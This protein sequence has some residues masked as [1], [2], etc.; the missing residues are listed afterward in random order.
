MSGINA[1]SKQNWPIWIIAGLTLVNGI[2]NI[3]YVLII[4][5]PE[6]SRV[7][8]LVLPYGL[9][10]WNRS[11]TLVFGFILMYLSLNLLKR[12][13]TA[14]YLTMAISVLIVFLHI[15][16]KNVI[17]TLFPPLLLLLLLLLWHKQFR[18][19]SEP[20]SITRGLELMLISLIIAV[21]YGTLGFW[22]LDK[23]DFGIE[24][25]LANSLVR[26]L[27]EFVLV[28]NNGLTANTRHARWFIDSIRLL[29]TV[30]GFFAMYSLF[31]PIVYR[32]RM[33]PHERQTL[34]DILDE[35]GRC[36]L[37]YFK[38]W[39]DKS[40]FFS[41]NRKCG[42]AYKTAFG[43]AI[44]LGDPVGPYQEIEHT[45]NDF[46]NYCSNNGWSIAFYQV[47]PDFLNMY[48][49]LGFGIV[50]IGEEA[51]INLEHFVSFTATNKKFRSIRRKFEKQNYRCTYHKPPHSQEIPRAIKQVSREWLQLAGRKERTFSV[52]EFRRDYVNRTPFFVISDPSGKILAFV[53]E[54]PSYHQGETTIDLMRHRVNVP[55]GTMDYLLLCLLVDLKERGYTRF[56]LGLAPLSGIGAT[57]GAS[58]KERTLHLLF[59]HT[60]RLFSFKGLREYKAKFEPQW[61]GRFI[62]YQG[63]PA[64]LIKTAVAFTRVTQKY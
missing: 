26:T 24:F 16:Q 7:L 5:F 10:H 21:V 58:L 1:M 62:A 14:F 28:G 9:V 11:S 33:L 41:K 17:H 61:E 8:S 18:V 27:R 25:H 30:A 47:L 42:I 2:A 36:S 20:T 3:A 15:I 52:G 37:D 51:V 60:K 23:K 38:L 29:G 56:S 19:Q 50:K 12:K 46:V 55:N 39:P 6:Q 54:I 44:S 13:R 35:Y 59:E 43:V 49:R 53:N 48:Q 64:G 45:V 22:L 31:R 34:Q 4:R 63:G 32:L 57:E 40:Y